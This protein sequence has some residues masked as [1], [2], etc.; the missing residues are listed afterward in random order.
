VSD[1]DDATAAHQN[2]MPEHLEVHSRVYR[3]NDGMIAPLGGRGGRVQLLSTSC[4]TSRSRTLVVAV[5]VMTNDSG[6][7]LSGDLHLWL[8]V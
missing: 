5:A 4:P 2:L 6:S 7:K 3:T 1:E 8:A